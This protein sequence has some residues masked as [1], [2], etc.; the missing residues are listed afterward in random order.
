MPH[1]IA[2]ADHLS[3]DDLRRRMRE[4]DDA[5]HRTH[6]QVV[7]LKSLGHDAP[8]I[9]EATGYSQNWVRTLLHRYNA[10]GEAGLRDRRADTPGAAPLLNEAQRTELEAA[11]AERHP[12][13]GLWSGPKVAR[14]IAERTGGERVYP[15][16][17]W[18]WL[19]RLGYTPQRPRPRHA[20]ADPAAQVAFK[21]S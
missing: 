8:A 1:S 20:E 4:A 12:D 7:Y 6:Y 9:A 17:G 15:Q 13:G 14:W 18:A 2:L 3:P 19:R 21:K 5:R 16:Q 10:D 11:L